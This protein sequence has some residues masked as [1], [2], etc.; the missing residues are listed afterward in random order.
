MET[1]FPGSSAR[2]TWLKS[3]YVEP[4]RTP[5]IIREMEGDCTLMARY[6]SS[7]GKEVPDDVLK[8]LAS[9]S[10]FIHGYDLKLDGKEITSDIWQEKLAQAHDVFNKL[11]I[12]SK[13]ANAVT[14]KYTE[15]RGGFLPKNNPVVNSLL[16]LTFIFLV[17]YIILNIVGSIQ[18]EVKDPL[19][20][21]TAS[22]LGAGFYT[23]LTVRKYLIDRTYNPRYNPTYVIRFFLGITAGSIL[24]FMF[25]DLF[26]EKYTS[27]VLAVVGGFSADAVGIILTRIS[28]ILIAAFQGIQKNSDSNA[29]LKEQE[30]DLIKKKSQVDA[31]EVMSKIK[32]AAVQAG[33]PAELMK[34]INDNLEKI[35][36]P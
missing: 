27:Q 5:D 12:L 18:K 9:L 33:V 31:I 16:I 10:V 23:L 13:P 26:D 21:I 14:I 29:E 28:E 8:N 1:K 7:I 25:P 17:I 20:I 35:G 4:V 36:K 11:S 32:S 6:V 15:F 2:K 34:T 22:A 24:A 30:K 3:S 19:L